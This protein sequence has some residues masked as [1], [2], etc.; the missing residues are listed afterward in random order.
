MY[1]ARLGKLSW[2][3]IVRKS[4]RGMREKYEELRNSQHASEKQFLKIA[5]GNPI[6]KETTFQLVIYKKEYME[7]L[8]LVFH[9]ITNL[10]YYK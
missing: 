7:Q 2:L 4:F 6:G 10:N 5:N 9:R 3:K 8:T 1:A